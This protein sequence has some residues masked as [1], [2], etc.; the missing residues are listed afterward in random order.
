MKRSCYQSPI[1][2]HI[3]YTV[4]LSLVNIL[5]LQ[6]LWTLYQFLILMNKNVNFHLIFQKLKYREFQVYRKVFSYTHRVFSIVDYYKILNIVPVVYSS[7]FFFTLY[8][9][10]CI[11]WASQMML[12]VK[13]IPATEG[14]I[15]NA[16]SIPGSGRA[17]GEK[18]GNPL[19]HSS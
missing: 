8:R 1:F 12:G 19:Q 4:F 6:H 16:G 9:V 18:H 13:N 11:C 2:H 3:I 14:Y 15:R 7:P 10:V 5:L 17:P